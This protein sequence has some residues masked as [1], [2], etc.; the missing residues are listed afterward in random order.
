MR[1]KEERVAGEFQTGPRNLS[2]LTIPKNQISLTYTLGCRVQEGD[3]GLFPSFD[4][5]VE[6]SSYLQYRRSHGHTK[7]Q[8]PRRTQI[9]TMHGSEGGRGGS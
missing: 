4:I 3:E 6:G 2:P 1:K 8:G 9:H 5:L 7:L